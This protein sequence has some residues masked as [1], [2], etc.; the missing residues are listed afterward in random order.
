MMDET[1]RSGAPMHLNPYE[2]LRWIAEGR[3]PS[4]TVCRLTLPALQRNGVWRPKQVLDLWRSLL[5]G[6]P[7]G[8]LYLHPAT[9]RVVDRDNPT[10]LI[11]PLLG[12]LDLFDGQQR[13][14]ALALGVGD[15]F[16]E[17]R[18]I[19][20]KFTGTTYE[21]V[22]SSRMQPAGYKPDGG[23]LP[24]RDRRNW[25]DTAK[26]VISVVLP[27]RWY[28]A[29]PF[30]CSKDDT[31]KLKDLL[32]PRL[33]NADAH[34]DCL[35]PL[36]ASEK[37][38]ESFRR[39]AINLSHRCAIF[40]L[41]P[42]HVMNCAEKTLS[43][44][45]RVGAGGTPLSQAEQV[46]SAYK[47]RKPE[48]RRVVETIHSS[49]SAPLTPAQIVQAA[50]RMAHTL[51]RPKTGWPPGFNLAIA[52]FS[53]R[54]ANSADWVAELDKLL[55]ADRGHNLLLGAFAT[56][57]TL[58]SDPNGG[59]FYLPE[60]VMAQLPQELWQVI[61]FWCLRTGRNETDQ[62]E[63]AVR[64]A[65]A[66]YLAVT[67]HERA[68]QVCFRLLAAESPARFPG[69]A[70]FTQMTLDKSALH[71]PAPKLLNPLFLSGPEGKTHWHTH[72]QRFP[73]GNDHSKIASTWWFS[74]KMLPWLQR[75][76]VEK[77]FAQYKPLSDHEDDLPYDWDH[78]CPKAHWSIG[79]QKGSSSTAT[80]QDKKRDEPWMVGDSV[81]NMRL[82]DYPQNRGDGNTDIFVKMPFLD[83]PDQST[84][85]GSAA[86]FLMDNVEE[87]VLWRAVGDG[88]LQRW[89]DARLNAFQSV[90]ERRTARLYKD[91][92]N[93][94]RFQ[95][96]DDEV[97]S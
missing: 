16:D 7:I 74:R 3:T 75:R 31:A 52:A 32:E 63:E 71:I 51:A 60:V 68:A 15:P 78:I 61:A 57:R 27:K 83:T 49:I 36:K 46:Y 50:L 64:F 29:Y 72:H 70:L 23:K 58:L 42:M 12:D 85:L 97:G 89:D 4:G 87:L 30:G 48:I 13:I 6:M 21:L 8:L 76:Y 38:W 39:D 84:E 77:K 69:K 28:P 79:G 17:G 93:Q 33:S 34:P 62:R 91:F 41:V 67:N 35:K 22:M 47:L 24:V 81:G 18:C 55:I 20:V 80:D 43:L 59:D 14:R 5:E 10:E 90:V 82:V 53:G 26:Q 11:K 94:L 65:M 66:W 2:V 9:D 45:Q 37:A 40:L 54:D 73:V 86:D 25:L 96:W 44:F 19:W 1:L 95:E 88:S 92:Y 56:T